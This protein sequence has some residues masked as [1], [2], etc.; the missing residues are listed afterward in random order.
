MEFYENL[1]KLRKSKNLSQEDLASKLGISRQAV[2][3]WESGNAYPE[4]EKLIQLAELFDCT[5]DELITGVMKEE[6]ELNKQEYLKHK[7]SFA[8][9]ISIGVSIVLLGVVL[10][11]FRI[12]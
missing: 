4:T 2:S 3:K 11:L 6:G 5:V 10:L 1:Q 12:Y 8:K 7:R 9:L